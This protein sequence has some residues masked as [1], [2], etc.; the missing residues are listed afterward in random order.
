M[1]ASRAFTLRYDAL[2]SVGRVQTPTL[3]L[4]VRRDGGDRGLYAPALLG[5]PRGLRRL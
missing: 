2:L 4:I 5:D 1:N 3:K